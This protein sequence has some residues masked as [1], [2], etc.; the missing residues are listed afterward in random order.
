MIHLTQEQL[1]DYVHGALSPQIDA[2]IYE[3]LEACDQCRFEYDAELALTDLIRTHAAGEERELPPTL[4]AEIWS[5]IRSARPS[6][7][8]R[9]V[10]RLRL[11]VAVP[12]AAAV[13]IAAYFGVTYLGPQGAPSI[14]AAYYLQDHA[15]LNSTIPFSDRAAMPV[16]LDNSAVLDNQQSAVNVQPATYTADAQ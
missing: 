5:R 16:N 3:H 2:A 11:S 13:A 8:S 14:E 1:I 4:K 9:L 7:W 12:V 6:P 15:A 10:E